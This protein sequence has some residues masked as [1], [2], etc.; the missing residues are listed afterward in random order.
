LFLAAR[1]SNDRELPLSF[2]EFDDFRHALGGFSSLAAFAN[3]PI[4]VGDEGRAPD[5]AN[6]T[7]ISAAGFSVLRHRPALGRD[8][9][10]R[11][12]RP[13]APGVAILAASFWRSRYNS[14][15]TIIGRSVRINGT[16]TIVVGVMRDGVRFPTNA[17]VWLPLAS[18]PGTMTDRRAARALSVVGRLGDDTA[19]ADVRGQL[20]ARARALSQAYADADAGITFTAVR[21]NDRYNGR[22]SDPVWMAFAGVG[23][24]VLLIACANAANLLLMRAARRGHEIAVRASLGASRFQLVRQLLVESAAL[25]ALG[26]LLGALL[27]LLS[28]RIIMSVIP[29]NAMPYWITFTMDARTFAAL[30][31]VCVVTVFVFGLAPAIHLARTDVVHL[32][33]EGARTGSPSRQTRRWTTAF[34]AAECGLTMVM[35]AALVLG[36]RIARAAERVHVVIDRSNLV[37]TWVT[38]SADR[39]RAADRRVAFFAQL[40]DRIRL[41]PT[42]SSAA[43]ATALP[44]SGASARQLAI[45]GR[46]PIAG[47]SP[48]TVWSITI[49]PRYFEAVGLPL[50]R[51]RAFEERDGTPGAESVI[52]NQRFVEMFFPASDALGRRIRLNEPAAPAPRAAWSTIVGIAPTVRQRSLPD[53]DPIVYVPLRGAPP[54]SAVL[55]V[56]GPN[57]VAAIGSLLRD[58]VRGIDPELPLY[59]VMS[60]DQA[61]TDAQW[62]GRVS[63]YLLNTIAF[64]A[65]CLAAIGLY[66]VMA[67][68]VVQR[69][70]EI[71]I[72]LA[73]G[74]RSR[75]VLSM[76][77]RHASVQ[78]VFG[79][80]AGVGCT[81]A[82]ERLVG[83]G[84]AGTLG[85]RM[86][87][88]LTLA[89]VALLLALITAVASI[90]PMLRATRVDPA[91]S[92]RFE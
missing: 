49:S 75:H 7:Y 18:M 33:K 2:R 71:G 63:E 10:D 54:V 36:L 80:I 48:P 45:D 16:P 53:P 24:V 25:A 1:D 29:E 82:F 69:T 72:R 40:D 79:L 21:I 73:L 77:L 44:L 3:A 31:G 26:G 90:A 87:D 20:P 85:Y 51:G 74:A 50:L 15:P 83:G 78:F 39:Y 70:R 19:L 22:I 28:I 8:F 68:A 46:P 57:S 14:D 35:L 4:V 30:C 76:V 61:L 52:V 43:V 58:A 11:D 37:T 41:I 17:D 13:G 6:G 81:F 66:A 62:N 86:S 56:R 9:D 34:L 38:L 65:V 47:Q 64:V 92:L 55:I 27:S 23:V 60:M 12:D 5:R 84:G 88:P 89:A 91:V 32:M 67:H 59:R 42:I